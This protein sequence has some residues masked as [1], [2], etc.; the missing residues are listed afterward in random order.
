[1]MGKNSLF[2]SLA[3]CWRED[4]GSRERAEVGDC[5]Y[6]MK[7]NAVLEVIQKNNKKLQGTEER[8]KEIY[9]DRH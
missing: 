9:F 2:C 8:K 3:K 7:W 4:G 5:S 6:N 1:M